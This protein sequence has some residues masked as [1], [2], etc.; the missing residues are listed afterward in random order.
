MKH[1][2]YHLQSLKFRKANAIPACL[3]LILTATLLPQD[4]SAAVAA[5]D[6]GAASDFAVLAGAGITVAGAVNTTIITGNIG[7]FSTTSI[8]G[9]ENV[10]L[11]GVNHAGD[12]LTQLA[13]LN[14][15]TAFTDAASR[16]AN[17]SFP[18]IY[19]LG[20]LTLAGGVYNEPSSLSITGTL[21]LD[22]GGDPNAIWIFQSNS[23]LITASG[24]NVFLVGGAQAG[25]VYWQVGSSATLGTG[26][27]LEGSIL[28]SDS[29]TLN[30]GATLKGRALALNGAVT[31]GYSSIIVPEVSSSLLLCVGSAFLLTRRRRSLLPS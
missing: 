10:I 27:H 22:G 5:L 23:T 16:L 24:S 3:F 17:T 4:A 13:K 6:L 8:T 29:I 9:L 1:K 7:S 26:S 30:T 14:L 2:H 21:T 15:E 20:G 25:N 12:S 31:M 18:P 11:N 28:A 19:D